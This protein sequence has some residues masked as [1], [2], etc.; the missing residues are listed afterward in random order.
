M[1]YPQFSSLVTSTIL[2]ALEFGDVERRP[3]LTQTAAYSGANVAS[4]KSMIKLITQH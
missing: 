1:F 3:Q 4:K 2:D